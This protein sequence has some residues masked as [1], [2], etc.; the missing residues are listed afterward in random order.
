MPTPDSY[1]TDGRGNR[2]PKTPCPRYGANV[3]PMPLRVE[4]LRHV[5]WEA[6]RVVSYQSWCGHTQEAIPFPRQD[7]SVLF[8]PVLG[9]AS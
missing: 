2:L 7:G 1:W 6:Y 4:N 9:E 5:G 3:G 8:V